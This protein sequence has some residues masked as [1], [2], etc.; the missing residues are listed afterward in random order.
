MPGRGEVISTRLNSIL[1]DDIHL[2]RTEPVILA[3]EVV[4]HLVELVQVPVTKQLVV[5]QVE[6]P[7]G[8]E[9]R[10]AVA[11]ARKVHPS[12]GHG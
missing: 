1:Y 11:L 4:H 3:L 7:P 2:R 8:V 6:L 5:D 10:V 12:A 9:E